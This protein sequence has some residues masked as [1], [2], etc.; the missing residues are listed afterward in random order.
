MKIKAAVAFEANKPLSIETVDLEGPKAGEVLI[1]LKATGVCHTDAL[2]MTGFGPGAALPQ[3]LG[4]EGAGVVAEVA[5][6]VTDLKPGDHVIPLYAP[7]CGKCPTCLSGRT[8]V[9]VGNTMAPMKGFMSDKTTRLSLNGETLHHFFGTSTF[10]EMTVVPANA[11]AK[12]DPAAPFDTVCAIGCGVTTGVGAA[13]YVADIK[14]GSCVAI[15]GLGGIG[16][17][18]IQGARI[19]GAERIIGIELNLAREAMGRSLG[20]TDFIDASQ[21]DN[22]VEAIMEMTQGG[23]ADTTFEC[24]GVPAVL[25]QAIRSSNMFWGHTLAIGVS[26]PKDVIPVAAVELVMG[27]KIEGL[28]FGGARGRTDVPK[29]VDMYM[30]G[31]IQIDP[32]I[33]HRMPLPDINSAFDLMHSGEAIRSVVMLD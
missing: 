30:R 3:I 1:D 18:A 9:C 16:L 31:D 5:S 27:R 28:Y 14:P 13:L 22:V 6:D 25:G 20:M 7:E 8:N 17:N 32:L 29:I 12:I 33:T 23:G 21:V 24:T 15:F 26:S 4:H 2:A 11:V 19:A 10:A